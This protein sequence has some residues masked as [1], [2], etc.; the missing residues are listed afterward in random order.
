MS[1]TK[2]WNRYPK[3]LRNFHLQHSNEQDSRAAGSALSGQPDRTTS[4]GHFQPKLL[5]D[6]TI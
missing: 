1:V 5:L 3:R 6:A 2:H 4:I